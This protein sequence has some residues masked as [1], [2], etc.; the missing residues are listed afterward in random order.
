MINVS[1]YCT[2]LYLYYIK[3]PVSTVVMRHF[4]CKKVTYI[5]CNELVVLSSTHLHR[6]FY[7]PTPS[8]RACPLR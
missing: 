2:Y 5:F 1:I 7:R 3:T 6:P 4:F 8:N